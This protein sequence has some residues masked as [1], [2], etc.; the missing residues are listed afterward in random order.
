MT[1]KGGNFL[2]ILR[3]FG[4][5][6]DAAFGAFTYFFRIERSVQWPSNGDL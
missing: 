6:S 2:S 1:W 5:L 4:M 3:Y